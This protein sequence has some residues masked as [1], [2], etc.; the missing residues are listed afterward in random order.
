MSEDESKKTDKPMTV[1]GGGPSLTIAD[2]AVSGLV[3]WLA[4]GVLDGIAADVVKPYSNLLKVT[5]NVKDDPKVIEWKAKAPN[6][7]Q[8]YVRP[9]L[10]ADEAVAQ[11]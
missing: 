7:K 4:M 9:E 10:L 8:F 11:K 6:F 2:L 3:N 1:M 5:A